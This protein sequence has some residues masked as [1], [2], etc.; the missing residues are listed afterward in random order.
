MRIVASTAGGASPEK[1]AVADRYVRAY[2]MGD[3]EA[4]AAESWLP[5]SW[6]WDIQ[7][8]DPG[9]LECYPDV[10]FGEPDDRD[11]RR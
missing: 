3:W 9:N 7:N 11:L 8:D 10:T 4:A 1:A 6:A 5:D 2:V